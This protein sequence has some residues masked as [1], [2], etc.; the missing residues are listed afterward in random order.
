MS[1]KEEDPLLRQL[2]AQ[3]KAPERRLPRPFRLYD[4]SVGDEREVVDRELKAITEQNRGDV[5]RKEDAKFVGSLFT[6]GARHLDEPAD[7][8]RRRSGALG[9]TEPRKYE[10]IE[11]KRDGRALS[12]RVN[13]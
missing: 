5:Y 11:L 8:H 13:R 10:D 9:H 3:A 1:D 12:R 7:E 2:L 6:G 4:R